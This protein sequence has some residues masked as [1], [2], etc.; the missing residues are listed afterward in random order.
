MLKDLSN[1]L[2]LRCLEE[3]DRKSLLEHAKSVY[4]GN[5]VGGS[6]ALLVRQ[7]LDH[8]PGFSFRDNFVV[9][10]TARNNQVVAWLCLLRKSCVFDGVEIIFS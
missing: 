7:L 1:D 4:E 6:V 10:D 2:I 5:L 9:V 3:S 8:Y